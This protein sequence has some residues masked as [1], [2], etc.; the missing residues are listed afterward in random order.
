MITRKMQELLD[1]ANADRAGLL[2]AAG[3]LSE[4]QLNYKPGAD[5]WSI[6]DILQHLAIVEEANGKLLARM[7]GK[8]TEAAGPAD[9]TPDGSVLGETIA[10]LTT[11]QNLPPIKAPERVAPIEHKPAVESLARLAASRENVT[12]LA[13]ELSAY[14]LSAVSFPHPVAGPLNLYAWLLFTGVHERRHTG[15]ISRIKA[16]AGFPR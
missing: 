13:A 15:Q 6:A 12:R 8:L 2:A 14:D 10:L 5:L 9:D 11:L 7:L 4:A 16:G 3:N 1:A